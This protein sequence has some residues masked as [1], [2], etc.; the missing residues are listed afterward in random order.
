MFSPGNRA[1]VRL[2]RHYRPRRCLSAHVSGG[3][4]PKEAISTSFGRM[5][6]WQIHGYGDFEENLEFSH[7]LRV[8]R[9][10]DPNEVIVKVAASS[11]NTIDLAMMGDKEF[12][13]AR[14]PKYRFDVTILFSCLSVGGYGAGFLNV[15][16][17]T[18]M[19]LPLT[20]GRDFAGE[21][22]RRGL[23][24]SSRQL[25]I[26]DKVWGVC[27]PHWPGCHVQFVRVHADHVAAQPKTLT[28]IEAGAVLYAGLTAW[29]GLFLSGN[30]IMPSLAAKRIL[31]LGASGGVG[32]MAVQICKA[33][34]CHVVGTGSKDAET[35]VRS[36][37]ADD[38][39]DYRDEE[40]NRRLDTD[41][42]IILDCAGRG[43]D[44]ANAHNWNFK[45]YITF[46]SPLLKH[47]DKDGLVAGTIKSIADVVKANCPVK[48]TR[49][50]CGTVKW[51]YFVAHPAGIEYLGQ[52][53]RSGRLK[54]VISHEV[55]F[56]N[57]LEAYRLVSKGH[58]RGKV[59]LSDVN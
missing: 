47:I 39:V 32:T 29:S 59:M 51:G 3:G 57:A 5:S 30:M 18:D 7:N 42:D 21:I 6:G 25:N 20:L 49:R 52:L 28:E 54:P 19:D 43:T 41:W 8:P 33:E 4:L 40:Y 17:R 53:A 22:V 15:M 12:G 16:R 10:E 38:F 56:G 46:S 44:Y 13:E 9:I 48:D 37:G 27:P 55:P 31:I 34:N 11:I 2:F 36:L 24:V 35:L 50:R 1:L 23:N 45:Q 58:L 26:G 14:S